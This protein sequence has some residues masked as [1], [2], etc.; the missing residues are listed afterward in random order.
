ME[1][2]FTASRNV[3]TAPVYLPDDDGKPLTAAEKKAFL[4]TGDFDRNLTTED[5]EDVLRHF[6]NLVHSNRRTVEV[7]VSRANP[8]ITYVRQVLRENGIPTELAYLPFVESNFNSLAQS[9]SGAVGMWQFMPR[10]GRYYGLEQDSWRDERRNPLAATRSAATYLK[11]LNKD[12][13]NWHLAVSAYNA[14][15]GKIGRALAATG[16]TSF[17]ELRKRN[18]MIPETKD[19]LAEETKQYLPK[20]LAVCKIMRNLE[21]LGFTPMNPANTELREVTVPAGSDLLALARSLNLS[22]DTFMI[23]NAGYLRYLSPPNASSVAYIPAALESRAIAFLRAAPAPGKDYAQWRPYRVEAGDTL[24]KITRQHGVSLAAVEK[25]NP[26]LGVLRPG[27]VILLPPPK[28]VAQA[29]KG[30]VVQ[31][32]KGKTA[33]AV[34]ASSQKTP[35]VNSKIA[36]VRATASTERG[37]QARQNRA[38]SNVGK[39]T[40]YMVQQGDTVWAIARKFQIPPHDLLA[41]NNM[42]MSVRLK[43][44]DVVM[45]KK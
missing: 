23:Y 12:F 42:D 5:M 2:P 43:P 45:V 37:T 19:Q 31:A 1:D 34:R 32:E 22:W 14:G 7:T 8:H 10:T 9:S 3:P 17:F 33:P 27:H 41:F 4:S 13:D 25:A 30:K 21:L 28:A 44:G 35:S 39:S 38:T 15:E 36:P 40:T 29:N 24:T 20:F 26:Y 6:K 11:K 18:A 16:T